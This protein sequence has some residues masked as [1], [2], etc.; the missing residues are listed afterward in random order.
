[1]FASFEFVKSGIRTKKTFRRCRR[2]YH[3]SLIEDP[4]GS[5][6]VCPTADATTAREVLSS[7]G[8]ADSDPCR[9]LSFSEGSFSEGDRTSGDS[10]V[11][12]WRRQADFPRAIPSR[13]RRSGKLEKPHL[14]HAHRVPMPCPSCHTFS[15]HHL[16]D[17]SRATTAT[18]R[19]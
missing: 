13:S 4:P 18:D 7:Q 17:L 5:L 6:G 14:M 9:S 8:L 11:R 12:V 16:D 10:S 1:L 3:A 2:N 15:E 19:L